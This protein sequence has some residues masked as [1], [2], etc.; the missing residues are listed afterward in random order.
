MKLVTITAVVEDITGEFK[1]IKL[2]DNTIL[3]TIK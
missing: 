1:L 3:N 2:T